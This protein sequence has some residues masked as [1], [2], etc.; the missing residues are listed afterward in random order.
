MIGWL[1]KEIIKKTFVFAKGG[2]TVWKSKWLSKSKA[3]ITVLIPAN[4]WNICSP[5]PRIRALLTFGVFRI[6]IT[7][8][9]V[10]PTA[11]NQMN[12]KVSH[13][14]HRPN[15]KIYANSNS[16]T[17]LGDPCCHLSPSLQTVQPITACNNNYQQS[18]SDIESLSCM[19]I[20]SNTVSVISRNVQ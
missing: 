12:W 4:C 9:D 6:R 17:G 18:Q 10:A 16:F 11:W 14:S 8:G 7:V 5:E 2:I 15:D 20:A 1:I 3:Y 19:W 13:S